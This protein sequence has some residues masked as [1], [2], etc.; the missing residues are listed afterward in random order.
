MCNWYVCII[1]HGG[2]PYDYLLLDV[3]FQRDSYE[4][5]SNEELHRIRKLYGNIC[6]YDERNIVFLTRV[7]AKEHCK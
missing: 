5:S 3:L 1:R 7:E 6:L 2:P 4:S